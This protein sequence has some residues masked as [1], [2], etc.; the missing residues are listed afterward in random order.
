MSVGLP[1]CKIFSCS[2]RYPAGRAASGGMLSPNA[3]VVLEVFYFSKG[4]GS[5]TAKR[6]DKRQYGDIAASMPVNSTLYSAG[7]ER[8]RLLSGRAG[9]F[10]AGRTKTVRR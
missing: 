2:G 5:K 10:A 7:A 3:V 6:I 8:N 4:C 9:A 1:R